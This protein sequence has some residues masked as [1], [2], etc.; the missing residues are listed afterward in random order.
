VGT[1]Y[2][3]QRFL[4]LAGI[5]EKPRMS[6]KYFSRAA[7]AAVALTVTLGFATPTF[8]ATF[9]V[10]KTAQA[11]PCNTTAYPEIQAAVAVAHKND[12]I[13]VCPGTYLVPVNIT[14]PLTIV[15][16]NGAV[17]EPN[18]PQAATNVATGE[19]V[20]PML[21]FHGVT[22]GQVNVVSLTVDGT[23]YP[24]C[25]APCQV[26][27]I[28]GQNS[29]G[30]LQYNTVRN[31]N[32][33]G[34]GDGIGIF[35]QSTPG[36]GP[37]GNMTNVQV[38]GNSVHDYQTNGIIANETGTMAN[39]MGNSVHGLGE[40]A[41]VAQGGIQVGFGAQ[42]NINQNLVS[43]NTGPAPHCV[44]TSSSVNYVS[45]QTPPTSNANVQIQNNTSTMAEIGI[46]SVNTTQVH[47]NNND[48]SDSI[49]TGVYLQDTN[50][51]VQNNDIFHTCNPALGSCSTSSNS[52]VPPPVAIYVVSGTNNNVNNNTI[53]ESLYGIA[54]NSSTTQ[55]NSEA[56][57]NV[58]FP[59]AGVFQNYSLTPAPQGGGPMMRL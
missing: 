49:C 53:N 50:D 15:G 59:F 46:G 54:S 8:A 56:I 13:Y 30:Q 43:D 33:G 22:G 34:A 40:M 19:P 51:Q 14:I 24:P 16:F 3:Y 5:K 31:V 57:Y 41:T 27:G 38:Q 21:W 58:T 12:T 39:M 10:S 36:T 42:G 9:Y 55:A 18:T 29:Q 23:N 17:L 35:L 20:S 47:I 2:I 7:L 1:R 32:V 37:P 28:F 6:R 44:G 11:A 45:Q 52:S 4:N 25:S 48:V 26:V